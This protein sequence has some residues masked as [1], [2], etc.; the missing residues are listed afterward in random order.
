MAHFIFEFKN[1]KQYFLLCPIKIKTIWVETGQIG[2][3]CDPPQGVKVRGS[4][5]YKTR[6][7][8]RWELKLA[9]NVGTS[10]KMSH[11]K[12]FRNRTRGRG[13]AHRAIFLG[14]MKA[15]PKCFPILVKLAQNVRTSKQMSCAKNFW[16][17]TR[18]R[19]TSHRPTVPCH[20]ISPGKKISFLTSHNFCNIWRRNMVFDSLK[21]LFY[22]LSSRSIEF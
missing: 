16:N 8:G 6:K 11:T 5:C 14:Y 3:P 20:I 12:N 13:T 9:Q 10:K 4:Q 17:R 7:G 21:S 18:G 22:W 2:P 19:D 15:I 1:L